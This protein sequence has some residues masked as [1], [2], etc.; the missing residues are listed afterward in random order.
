MFKRLRPGP[1]VV[2][3]LR[4]WT[5]ELLVVA[6]GVLLALWAQAWFE[7]RRDADSHRETIGQLD[8]MFHRAMVVAAAR[9]SA[10]DCARRRI[11][12]LD[13][14]LRATDGQWTAMPIPGLP[15]PMRGGQFPPVYLADSEV[16]P[17]ALF[18][19]ARG[20]GTLAALP[21]A[22]RAW[23][24][25]AERQLTWLREA[26]T[27]AEAPKAALALLGVDGPLG[28]AARDAMRQALVT[29]D[30]E[31]HVVV[32]RASSLARLAR[33][34]GIA[35]AAEDLAAYREKLA[36][37]RGFFGDCV[38][39]VDPLSMQPVVRQGG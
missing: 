12:E 6:I 30:N 28:D 33:E 39:E 13:A 21:P 29:L 37:D 23:Y 14:A 4:H 20:N 25:Q 18:D 11:A 5:S 27:A 8:R 2:Q 34:R 3:R 32:I 38:V 19:L 36:R 26:W 24:E 16:L 9:V 10:A 17:T 31:N 7:A 15:A 35:L 22:S 1:G